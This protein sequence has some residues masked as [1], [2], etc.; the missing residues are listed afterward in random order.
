[1]H[2]QKALLRQDILTANK[3]ESHN[4]YSSRI[5]RR[6]PVT[7]DDIDG[8]IASILEK[9]APVEAYV[10]ETWP[11]LQRG[12]TDLFLGGCA[13]PKVP[14]SKNKPYYLYISQKEDM[15]R[16]RAELEAARGQALER[17]R[18]G[19]A[20]TPAGGGLPDI[21]VRRLPAGNDVGT[22]ANDE[23]G[24]LYVPHP[25]IVPGIRYNEMYNW[26]SMFVVRG[27]LES[28]QF[29]A[30]KFLVDDLLYEA[31][32][33]GTM[34]NG[35]RTYYLDAS[36]SRSQ[37]PLITSKVLNIFD[38][39]DKLNHA[40]G[41]ARVAWLTR[42]AATVESYSQH[43]ESPP[44]LHDGSGLSRYDSGKSVPSPE[45]EYGEPGHYE[46]ALKMLTSMYH[47]QKAIGDKPSLS[48]Q[49]RKDRYYL[50][51]YLNVSDD[52]KHFSLSA[53]FYR[54]DDAMRESGF[55][56]SRRFGIYN[57]DI[58][59]HL[60]VCLNSLRLKME[61]EMV[62]IY[63]RLSEH[64]P[65]QA[66]DW[67]S[68]KT[69]WE[70]KAAET[71]TLINDWLWDDG[72]D[73][74]GAQLR[75]PCYRDRNT[76]TELCKKYGIPEFR[77]YNFATMLFPLWVGAADEGQAEQTITHIL[78]RL[79]TGFGL[80]TSDRETG[81]QWDKPMMWAPLQIVAVEALE[82]YG[83]Y[84]DA[85]DI[86]TGF[87]KTMSQDFEMTGKLW[88]KYESVTGSS[89]IIEH[90]NK[91]YSVNDEGFG[92]TNAAVLELREAVRRLKK[93]LH[94]QELGEPEG[95]IIHRPVKQK[96]GP[97]KPPSDTPGMH[98]HS[99]RRPSGNG[100]LPPHS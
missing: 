41:E 87:L 63:Q 9:S 22:L 78:P 61:E 46:G 25:Y 29:D 93:K 17:I 39:W 76:N 12:L 27:L 4:G 81:C 96:G 59:N 48:Y 24:L 53:D 7:L 95:V 40:N 98:T 84:H 11:T 55:D 79:K 45:V 83:H 20:E 74:E 80:N 66:R 49:D 10:N 65:A 18:A 28:N 50:E 13:D 91:G 99:H 6:Q 97:A 1:M 85:L 44:H 36:K 72:K 51:Q 82:R 2:T 37:P 62:E 5:A 58:I 86:A 3:P 70:T 15:D 47:R 43:W 69:A 31:D 52:G 90:V 42:A 94:Q 89:N 34:L 54:G 19:Q 75:S 67:S 56:P 21:E 88:E 23:H 68:K 60:P 64:D 16:V 92:W 8:Q 30:A 73:A 57:V 14:H 38:N 35:N 26:D 32:H 71:K 77:D 33:Y 100:D